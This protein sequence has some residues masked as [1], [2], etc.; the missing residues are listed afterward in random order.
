MSDIQTEF[1]F[2][3]T[4]QVP[5]ITDLGD[6]PFG[7]RRIAEVSGGRFEGPRLKG[8]AHPGGGDWILLRPDGA[9][10]L[11]VRVTLE[12]DDGEL[13]YMTYR[14]IRHGPDEVMA[15]LNAGEQVDPSEYYFRTA[16]FFET[17]SEKYGWLNRIVSVSTGHRTPDGPVYRVYQVL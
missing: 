1:L 9:L 5:R 8:K 12:T 4:F 17:G 14:G 3:V 11:D 7:N 10:Q 2:E 16:P 15:R 6:T 13:I